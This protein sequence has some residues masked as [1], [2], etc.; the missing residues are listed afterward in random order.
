MD[1]HQKFLA[2][3]LLSDEQPITYRAL[4]RVLDV[5]V[6]TAKRIL[7]DFHQY[8]NSLRADSVHA[9]YLLYGVKSAKSQQ[10]DGADVEMSSSMP[11]PLPRSEAILTQTLTLVREE[12][13]EALLRQYQEHAR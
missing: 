13:L 7:Y 4:S 1:E 2:D 12:D 8:Q 3:R 10:E 5:H 9:T 6:N 11:E